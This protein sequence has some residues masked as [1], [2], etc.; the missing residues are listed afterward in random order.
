MKIS[1]FKLERF[2]AA[3]EFKAPYV[4]CASDCESWSIQELLD[5]EPDSLEKFEA[6][7][8]GYMETEGTPALRDEVTKLYQS[9]KLDE[10]LVHVGA[11]EAIFIFMNTAFQK[12]DHVIVHWPC[13]QSLFEI[14][15]SLGCAITKWEGKEENGWELDIEFLKQH[16][17]KNTKAIII[18]CPHNPTGYLMG[19]DKLL[20]IVDIARRHNITLFSDEVYRFLEYD[21]K[22]LLPGACD[23]YKNAVSVGVMSK[24]FG[25]AGLRIGWAATK[26]KDIY[27]K[28]A[29]LKDY[30]SICASAPSEF[31]AALALRHKDEVL[32]RN[33]TLILNNLKILN[34]FFEKYREI[35]AWKQP[36][37]GAIAFPRLKLKIG[38]EKFCT[39][40]MEKKGVLLLPSN[41]YD[42]GNKH[43]RFG[44]G[45]KNMSECVEKLDEYCKENF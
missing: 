6:Q 19:K 2:F 36:K 38:A 11:Q 1:P 15:N 29:S 9:I 13:Y 8:L 34:E 12:G 27:R 23:L 25:L 3:Y 32:R 31:L 21:K 10:V 39:D 20:H 41:Y 30:T 45:R 26:N 28:M 24:T 16:I 7:W 5:F 17:R 37:A 4:L 42:Y 35:F 22:D 18:N 43:V 33:L 40:L 14:A 44:F